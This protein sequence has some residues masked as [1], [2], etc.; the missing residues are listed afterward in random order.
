MFMMCVGKCIYHSVCVVV[1]GQPCGNNS[2][3]AAFYVFWNSVTSLTWQG[4]LP[5]GVGLS[6]CVPELGK[7]AAVSVPERETLP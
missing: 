1:R 6:P 2:P 4:F 7:K 3:F 5:T